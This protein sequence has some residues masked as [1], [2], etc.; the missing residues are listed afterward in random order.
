V[1]RV[2]IAEDMHLIRGAVV[3]LLAL[4]EDDLPG[5]YDESLTE[6]WVAFVNR[7]Y[8]PLRFAAHGLQMLAAYIAQLAPASRITNCATFVKL[9]W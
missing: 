9:L 4:E 7:W 3:A 5:H 2:L 1:I 6:E 8:A